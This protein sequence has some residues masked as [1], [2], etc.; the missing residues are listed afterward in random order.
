[1][2]SRTG[3]DNAMLGDWVSD[4]TCLVIQGWLD[5][6]VEKDNIFPKRKKCVRDSNT[7]HMNHHPQTGL[8]TAL[9]VVVWRLVV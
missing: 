4:N 5:G 3:R 1:M 6:Q 7:P 9:D 2:I 8:E